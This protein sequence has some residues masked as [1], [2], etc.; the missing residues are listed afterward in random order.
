MTT[1]AKVTIGFMSPVSASRPHLDS[2]KPFVPE[3]VELHI[4]E[5]G[6][7]GTSQSD[8]EG[9]M[10]YILDKTS[11]FATHHSWEGVIVPGAPVE[12]HNPGLLERLQETL[13]IP[14]VTA[15]SSCVT[16][17][18]AIKAERVVFLTP[19]EPETNDLLRRSI[20]A[21]GI[22]AVIAQQVFDRYD[23]AH[24]LSPEQVYETTYRALEE[25]GNVDAVYFQG[26][27]LDPLPVLDD[28]EKSFGIPIFASNT[29]MLW[30]ILSK[31]NLSYSVDGA[32][33]LLRDWPSPR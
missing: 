24:D 12:L 6:F 5:V 21:S 20:S 1:E 8:F 18:Q 11:I 17:I 28:M 25:S 9:R 29:T 15:L 13:S 30:A 33:M 10:Q 3:G 19:F 22:E 23:D 31:M 32:G 4:E 16:A 14:A 7:T 2:F 27:I 26:A